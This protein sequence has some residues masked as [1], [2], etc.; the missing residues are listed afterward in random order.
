MPL[1][2]PCLAILSPTQEVF[3]MK[4]LMVLSWHQLYLKLMFLQ[5]KKA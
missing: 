5:M 4:I 2:L 3:S 1:F